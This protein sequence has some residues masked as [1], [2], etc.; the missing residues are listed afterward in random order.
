MLGRIIAAALAAGALAVA[1]AGSAQAAGDPARGKTVFDQ[2]SGCHVLTGQGFGGPALAGVVG[3]KAGA[4]AGFSYSKAMTDSGITWSEDK[5]DK[6]L[7]SPSDLVPGTSMFANL[8]DPQD[9]ADVIAYLK[10]QAAATSP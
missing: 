2:C 8:P 6:F 9:R 10:T 7:I 1:F 4:A 5:L 3:R